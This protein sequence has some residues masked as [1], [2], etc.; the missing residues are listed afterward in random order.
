M[1]FADL[2]MMKF[3]VKQNDNFIYIHENYFLAD[4]H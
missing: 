3:E 2:E 1:K 4:F